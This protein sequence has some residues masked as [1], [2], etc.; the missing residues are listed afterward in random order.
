MNAVKSK[1]MIIEKREVEMV[2]FSTP[3]WVS[4]PAVER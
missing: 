4:M 3:Y 2:D 1:V